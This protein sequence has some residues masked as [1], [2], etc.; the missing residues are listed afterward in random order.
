MAITINQDPS[1]FNVTN[2]P[3][4]FVAS[5]DNTANN[6]FQYVLDVRTSPDG[7]L[8]A[9]IK[10][11]PNPDGSAVFDVSHTLN[12]YIEYDADNFLN[13]GIQD[14]FGDEFRYFNIFVGEEYGTSP[15]SSVTLYDGLGSA[16]DPAVTGTNARG[17]NYSAFGG[18]ID[19]TPGITSSTGGWNFGDYFGTGSLSY[20]LSNFRTTDLGA[21]STNHKIGRGDYSLMPVIDSNTNLSTQNTT[22][23]LYNSSDVSVGSAVLD[24]TQAG[25]YMN[26]VPVGP[27][28]FLDA[29]LFTQ[30]QINQTAWYSVINSGDTTNLFKVFTIEDCDNN[31]ERTNFLFINKWGLWE[32]YGM[33][34]ALRQQTSISRDEYKK[35][36]VPFSNTTAVNSYKLRGSEYYNTTLEDTFQITTPFVTTDEAKFVTELIESPQVYLQLNNLDMGLGTTISKTFVPVQ[37]TNS[38]YTS[39]TNK[40]QKIFQYNIEYTLANQRPGK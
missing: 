14:T 17:N 3:I 29:G 2:N 27:Q 26:Y 10:Q 34:T 6:Q 39:K 1:F 5:S 21:Y 30:T 12:D 35:S 19:Y 40:L 24:P 8:R 32:S 31:Y 28:N 33:N 13:T 16:G 36:V 23:T 4:V 15:S 22:I 11:Y 7:I 20:I 9:R 18:S 37:I 38:S 25:L